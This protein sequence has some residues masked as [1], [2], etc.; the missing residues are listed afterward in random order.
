MDVSRRILGFDLLRGICA[1]A[2]MINHLLFW[3]YGYSL[4]NIGTYGVYI[5]FILSGASMTIAYAEKLA[6][7]MSYRTFIARRYFRVAPLYWLFVLSRGA[8]GSKFGDALLNITFLFGFADPGVTG[9][10]GGGWSLG[11]EFVFY[12]TFP[13]FLAFANTKYWWGILGALALQTVYIHGVIHNDNDML[14]HRNEYTQFI[15]FFAYFYMGCAIGRI[16]LKECKIDTAQCG[17]AFIGLLIIIGALCANT[18][19]E[20]IGNFTGMGLALACGLLVLMSGYLHILKWMNTIVLAAGSMSYGVYLLHFRMYSYLIR[21]NLAGFWLIATTIALTAISALVL[22]KYFE[23]PIKK[24]G[25]I[26]LAVY[27]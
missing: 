20:V 13:L 1:I 5:F 10:A 15:S 3:Q 7:G 17:A 27:Q 2:I 9:W 25:Y 21:L 4:G 14:A 22:E 24:W 6:S 18:S 23:R 8:F 26:R 11:I 12:F 16:L 19:Y